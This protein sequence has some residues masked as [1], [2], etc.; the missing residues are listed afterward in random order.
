MW[1]FAHWACIPCRQPNVVKV[2]LISPFKYKVFG[3]AL[4][5]GW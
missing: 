2:S 5:I 4:A 3:C 1:H